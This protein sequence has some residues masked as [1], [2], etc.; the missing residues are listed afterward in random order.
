M[1][2]EAINLKEQGRVFG[3]VWRHERDGENDNIIISKK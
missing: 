3:W 2:K 1:R